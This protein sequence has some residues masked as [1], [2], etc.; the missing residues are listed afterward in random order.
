MMKQL[1][2]L[3]LGA[4]MLAGTVFPAL[5][6]EQLTPNGVNR[7]GATPN[8]VD[9]SDVNVAILDTGVQ[10]DHPD[11]NVVGG[12]D[13]TGG[14]TIFGAQIQADGIGP[15]TPRLETHGPGWDDGYG[16]GTHV[17]GTVAA[18][19]NDQG[20]VGVAPGAA[21]WSVRVLDSRGGGTNDTILCGLDWV[22]EY[23][24]QID[25]LNL[26]LGGT[27]G[28]YLP[29][30]LAACHYEEPFVA[31]RLDRSRDSGKLT[32][33]PMHD[34]MC[35]IL[36]LGIPI[37]VSAGNDDND[38][39]YNFP[40]G[41]PEVITVSNFSDFD[42]QPG[43]LG[44]NVSCLGYGGTDDTLWTHKN[45]TPMR[46]FSS[47]AG[48]VVDFSAPGT[49]VL[50]TIPTGFGHGYGY[51]T[52]TSMAAPHVTGVVTRI[53]HDLMAETPGGEDTFR[54][55]RSRNTVNMIEALMRH[56]AEP[57][58]PDFHDVDEYPEPLIHVP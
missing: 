7:V 24:D 19:D 33:V 1:S 37:V 42:G 21:I 4:A 3:L 38:A 44:E 27:Q 15:F 49:C 55:M 56:A 29:E 17:A 35:T 34:R 46:G 57:Q 41:F 54:K 8:G 30:S 58:T 43:G 47:S 6:S 28:D 18:L 31:T 16:H 20:V 10:F 12:V 50:S 32:G 36:D 26:S 13:C 5:A 11:L 48:E 9:Y 51:A 52:G 14:A 22:I 53:L 40:A 39:G 25:V 23:H 2:S 45:G